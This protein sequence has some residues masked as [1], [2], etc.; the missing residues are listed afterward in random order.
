MPEILGEAASYFDPT[1]IDEMVKIIEKGLR[2]GKSREDLINKGYKKVKEYSWPRMAR[3][4]LD[5]YKT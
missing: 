5:I 2:G 3:E 1:N 4:T